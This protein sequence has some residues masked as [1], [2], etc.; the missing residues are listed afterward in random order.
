MDVISCYELKTRLSEVMDRVVT[1]RQPLVVTRPN[2]E[3]VVLLPLADWQSTAETLHVLG[4][5]ANATR[6]YASVRALDAGEGMER[7]L[8]EAAGLGRTET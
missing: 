2:G 3:A 5:R 7:E 1:D 4:T 6:L 8:V